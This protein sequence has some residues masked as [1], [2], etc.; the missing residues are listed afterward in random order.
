MVGR[1]REKCEAEKKEKDLGSVITQKSS[2][3]GRE[4][5]TRTGVILKGG[6]GEGGFPKR[7]GVF[8]GKNLTGDA[9]TRI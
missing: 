3:K 6:F 7:E 1:E 2:Q 9:H 8:K 5:F 4:F